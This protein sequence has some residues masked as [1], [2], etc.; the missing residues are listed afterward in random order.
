VDRDEYRRTSLEAWQG[1][2]AGWERARERLEAFSAPVREWL[3]D[4]L[5]ARPGDTVLELAAGPGET[6][7]QVIRQLGENGRLIS[8]DRA[9]AM[10]EVARRRAAELGLR[11]VE[12]RVLDAEALDLPD[13]SVDAVLCRF[14]YMLMADPELALTETRRVLRPGGRLALA[15]W[16]TADRN[17]WVSTAGRIFVAR[18][19]VPSPEPGAPGMFVM[20]DEKRTRVML[21]AAGFDEIRLEEVPVRFLF[22][23]VDEYVRRSV[24]TGGMFATVFGGASHDEQEA[25]KAELAEKFARFAADGGYVVPGVALCAAAS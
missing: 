5:A 24:E 8:S 14:G 25:I 17:P 20:A 1:M 9:P 23:D 6:G 12:H 11:N 21:E 19:L 22:E 18:G 16:S 2:A 4:A 7:F 15:V 13:D 10:V 3:V